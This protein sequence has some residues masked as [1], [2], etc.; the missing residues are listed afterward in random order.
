MCALTRLQDP[1][2]PDDIVHGTILEALEHDSSQAVRAA[3]LGFI[4][5]TPTSK[6]ALL[7]R[8][9]DVTPQVRVAA[10]KVYARTPYNISFPRP[11]TNVFFRETR[12]SEFIDRHACTA[13]ARRVERSC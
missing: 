8:S 11:L 6:D 7:R 13:P 5:V 3:A 12:D 1:M 2:S 10:Y 4:A 9:R